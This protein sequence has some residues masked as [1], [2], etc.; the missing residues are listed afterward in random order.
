M[1]DHPANP[2]ARLSKS[3]IPI[4]GGS[5]LVFETWVYA[6]VNSATDAGQSNLA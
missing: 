3:R 4:A 5:G 6:Y 2:T 1:N